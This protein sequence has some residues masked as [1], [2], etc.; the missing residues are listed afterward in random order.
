[1]CQNEIRLILPDLADNR[2]TELKIGLQTSIRKGP[3]FA[4]CTND[5]GGA[6]SLGFATLDQLIG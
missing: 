5:C 6:G 2:V 4:F 1:M 3:D